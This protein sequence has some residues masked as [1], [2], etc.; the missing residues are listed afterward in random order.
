MQSMELEEGELIEGIEANDVGTL[1]E[2]FLEY[3]EK[4]GISIN[5]SHM[6]QV[7]IHLWNISRT[8]HVIPSFLFYYS[9][10]TLAS[11]YMLLTLPFFCHQV[12]WSLLL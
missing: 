9:E 8:T 11:L 7:Y 10:K 4:Q 6:L 2:Q 12:H 3:E 5:Q 1:L